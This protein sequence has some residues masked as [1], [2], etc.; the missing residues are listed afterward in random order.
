MARSPFL[1]SVSDLLGKDASPRPEVV[2]VGVDWG[3]ELIRLVPDPPLRADLMLHHVSGGVAVTGRASFTSVDSC[4]RCL[5]TTLTD[6]SVPIAALFDRNPDDESYPLDG[7]DI[8]VEQMLRDEVILSLPITHVCGDDC[9]GVVNSAQTDLNT[10]PSGDEGDP[11]SP[12][13]VLK[14]LLDTGDE[15]PDD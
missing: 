8:D 10:E 15:Q 3:I 9:Q 2:E 1:L 5:R 7:N 11:R 6:R 14:D 4:L 13:A 12:F